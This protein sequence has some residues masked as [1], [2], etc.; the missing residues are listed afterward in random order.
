MTRGRLFKNALPI[1]HLLGFAGVLCCLSS[2][3]VLSLW[4]YFIFVSSY[5]NNKHGT[6]QY[7]EIVPKDE[8]DFV[9]HCE[10]IGVNASRA[11]LEV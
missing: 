7:L 9:C 6:F 3:V 2:S 4:I 1:V 11:V 10:G 8:P 5:L